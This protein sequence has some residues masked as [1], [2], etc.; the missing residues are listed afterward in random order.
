MRVQTITSVLIVLSAVSLAAQRA[1]PSHPIGDGAASR[2]HEV[3]RVNGVALTSVRL[4]AALNALLPFES[5]HSSVS[6]AKLQEVRAKALDQIVNE[7]LQYQEGVRDAIRI[8]DARVRQEVATLQAKYGTRDALAAA[9]AR[10]GATMDDLTREVRRRLTLNEAFERAVTAKCQVT[11]AEASDFFNA[12]PE[13]FVVPEELHLY[14]I[15]IGVEPAATAARWAE[16]KTRAEDVRRQLL[17]GAP[18]GELARRYSTDATRASG[19][20]MGLLHRGSLTD[21]FE[22]AVRSLPLSRPSEVVQSLYGYHVV[23]ITEIRPSH[24]MRFADVAAD[25]QRDLTAKRCESM[26]Q[27]WLADLRAHAT[28]VV[29]ESAR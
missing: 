1:F 10:S 2:V 5:F 12:N 21:E 16:A 7:E 14:A 28:V 3:A 20:D 11:R 6:Q 13:R 23:E 9:L 24:R 17:G 29:T 25:V 26:K 19:G 4:D 18:F 15:T 8:P 22:R 27:A